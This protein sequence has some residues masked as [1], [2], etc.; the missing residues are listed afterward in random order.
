MSNMMETFSAGRAQAPP[1]PVPVDSG[2]TEAGNI[3]LNARPIVKN[4]DGTIST[5]RSIDVH[6]APDGKAVL[7]KPGVGTRV[8]IP[9][10]SE[11]GRVMSD[12]VAVAQ[13][14]STGRHLGVFKTSKAAKDYAEKLHEDQAKQYGDH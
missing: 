8:V 1:A 11:D 4:S 5:V 2:P 10:V 3:D 6:L 9:T 7:G 13:Y 12:E 14:N